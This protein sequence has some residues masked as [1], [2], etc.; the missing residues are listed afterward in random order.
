VERGGGIGADGGGPVGM[1]G[2]G[3]QG[4]VGGGGVLLGGDEVW[5]WG[6]GVGLGGVWGFL[7]GY[8]GWGGGGWGIGYVG[9]ESTLGL[10]LS[11]KAL[12]WAKKRAKKRWSG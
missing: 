7:G 3:W 8:C 2:G 6:C 5:V 1:G 9:R 10:R 4:V 11:G 12:F